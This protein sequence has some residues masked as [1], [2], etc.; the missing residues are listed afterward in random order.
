MTNQIDAPTAHIIRSHEHRRQIGTFFEDPKQD[1]GFGD[2]EVQRETSAHHHW[3][4]VMVAYSLLRLG[5]ATSA[6]DAIRPKATSLRT[7][8]EWSLKEANLQPH[9]LDPEA[10]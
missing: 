6:P 7:E 8:W 3:Q 1:L 4:L 9:H 10:A 2:C 5:P